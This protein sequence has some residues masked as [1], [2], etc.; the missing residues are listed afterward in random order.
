MPCEKAQ[1]QLDHGKKAACMNKVTK[2][3]LMCGINTTK[4]YCYVTNVR[5]V[6]Q[7]TTEL[8][9]GHSVRWTCGVDTD[10]REI[11]EGHFCRSCVLP[12]WKRSLNMPPPNDNTRDMF[13]V[14]MRANIQTLL[15]EIDIQ[16]YLDIPNKLD[17][18]MKAR[19]ATLT[20]FYDRMKVDET[21]EIRSSPPCV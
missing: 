15:S 12:D 6:S 8:V 18:F 20:T 7:V 17:S 5:C 9:C 2:L 13:M 21:C 14:D 16:E 10:P 19:M 11:T 4:N 1:L 3:C